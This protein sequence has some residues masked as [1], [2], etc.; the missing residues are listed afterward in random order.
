MYNKKAKIENR[1]EN[2]K[3]KNICLRIISGIHKRIEG[4]E[5]RLF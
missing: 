1:I 3:S 4:K 2:L 5:L